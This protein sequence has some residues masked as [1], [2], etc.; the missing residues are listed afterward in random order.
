[1]PDKSKPK[2]GFAELLIAVTLSGTCTKPYFAAIFLV[3]DVAF[4]LL[5]L[6]RLQALSGKGRDVAAN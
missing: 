4:L 3:G 5:K 1:M 2:L 6:Q